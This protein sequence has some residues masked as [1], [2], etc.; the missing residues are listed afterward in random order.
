MRL[1]IHEMKQAAQL[2]LDWHTTLGLSIGDWL[3]QLE[4][5]SQNLWSKSGRKLVDLQKWGIDQKYW[6]KSGHRPKNR[7]RK[8]VDDVI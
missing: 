1:T 8:M 6:S 3:K 5:A 7:P 2:V 4:I